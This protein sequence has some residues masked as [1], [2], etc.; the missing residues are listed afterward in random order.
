MAD[1][2]IKCIDSIFFGSEKSLGRHHVS[3]S[4]FEHPTP[5][6][7]IF[8]IVCIWHAIKEWKTG[9]KTIERFDFASVNCKTLLLLYFPI[10]I[11][12]H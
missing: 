5:S 3:A 2:V 11:Y 10:R 6:T 7:L 9:V 8:A 4:Y 1:I 12:K